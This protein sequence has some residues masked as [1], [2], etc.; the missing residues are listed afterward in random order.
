MLKLIKQNDYKSKTINAKLV[1]Y[2]FFKRK[3]LQIFF[4]KKEKYLDN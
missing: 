2:T 1:N 4:S 3:K